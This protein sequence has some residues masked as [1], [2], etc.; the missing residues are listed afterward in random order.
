MQN[1]YMKMAAGAIC[2]FYLL[3][4]KNRI[5]YTKGQTSSISTIMTSSF[6]APKIRR[7]LILLQKYQIYPHLE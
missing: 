4:Q 3:T 7:Q 2:I 5:F 6:E 1:F